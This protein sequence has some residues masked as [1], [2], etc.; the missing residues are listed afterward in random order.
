MGDYC[1]MVGL[2]FLLFYWEKISF[3][4]CKGYL[5]LKDVMFEGLKDWFIIYFD[6][7][8]VICFSVDCFMVECGILDFYCCVEIVFGVFGWCY[9]V[10][11]DVIWIIFD[12]VV[13]SEVDVG[14]LEC[15]LFDIEI[16]LGFIGIVI[17]EDWDF[18]YFVCIF[19]CVLCEMVEDFGL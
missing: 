5:F 1:D 17:C 10:E 2:N 18:S 13:V 6:C 14:C 9:V 15:L 7:N 3:I 8:V 12:G 4:V 11:S 19:R 16:I